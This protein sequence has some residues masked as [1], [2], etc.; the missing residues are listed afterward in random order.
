MSA[1]QVAAMTRR[2]DNAA[3]A[4]R[5]VRATTVRATCKYSAEISA[6]LRVI[7]IVT[8]PHPP[9]NRPPSLIISTSPLR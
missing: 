3:A 5:D 7:G 9:V 8:P 4:W 1:C 6:D 2:K